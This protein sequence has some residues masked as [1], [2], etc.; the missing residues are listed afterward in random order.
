MFFGV[1]QIGVLRLAGS[2][3]GRVILFVTRYFPAMGLDRS[4]FGSDESDPY[5]TMMSGLEAPT[6]NTA[7]AGFSLHIWGDE[8]PHP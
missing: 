7:D 1:V 6:T 3:F 5:K 8:G 2:V 4:R